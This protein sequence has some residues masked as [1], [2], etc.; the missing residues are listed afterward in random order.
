MRVPARYETRAGPQRTRKDT[1]VDDN[2]SNRPQ[3]APT[4]SDLGKR[5]SVRA[6]RAWWDA[7]AAVYAAEHARFLGDDRPEGA[8]IWGPEGWSE[9]DLGLLGNVAGARVLEVGAGGA[10]GARWIARRGGTPVA[11]DVS[12]AMLRHA[13]HQVPGVPLV[14]ADAGALPFADACFDLAFSAYGALPFVADAGVVHEEVA[15]VLRPGG[16]W[17][18]SVTHPVRWAFPDSPGPE[19]LAADRP[20]FDRTPYVE[21]DDAGQATYVEHHR[22]LGDTVRSLHAA[23]LR[24]VDLIEPEWPEWNS[25]TWGGWSPQRGAILPG[26]AIWVA[27]R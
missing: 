8:L 27:E 5:E 12:H 17:V 24:L 18:F 25:Q 22:T 2:G 14:Q 13:Q 3:G 19:G 20:Y 26:T 11:L 23:G 7:E 15:R 16:R 4:R 9:D 1:D 21:R 6:S 10:Q